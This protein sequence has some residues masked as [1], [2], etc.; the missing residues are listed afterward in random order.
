MK[1]LQRLLSAFFRGSDSGQSLVEY[2]M[3]VGAVALVGIAGFGR[4]GQAVKS[5]LGANARHIEGEGLPTAEGILGSLGADYNELPGWCVK[6]N[7]CFAAG[8]PVQTEHGDRA[9]ESVRVG[10]RIWAR[11]LH[12]GAVALRPVV[13]T[14]R[15]SHV[16]VVDLELSFDLGQTEQLFV[17]RNHLFWVEGAGWVRADALA[18]QP[19][20][21][22]EAQLSAH[23]HEL[24]A[25]PTTVYN[26]EVSDFHSY[27]VGH[28]H[29]L[30][31][32]GDPDSEGCP[33][34]ADDSSNPPPPENPPPA[35]TSGNAPL[36]CGETGGYKDALG[37]GTASRAQR[38]GA[39]G[40][41]RDH[42]PSGQA[43]KTRAA[44]VLDQLV[45][46]QMEEKCRWL[47]PTELDKL[48]EEVA[49]LQ[50]AARASL[51]DAVEDAGFAIA[52]PRKFHYAGR[53]RGSKNYT[54][55][56]PLPGGYY[57]EQGDTRVKRYERDSDDLHLAAQEDIARY[58]RLLGT[59]GLR[60][61]DGNLVPG[62]YTGTDLSSDCRELILKAIE[63][64]RSKTDQQYEQELARV[65]QEQLNKAGLNGLLE[66]KCSEPSASSN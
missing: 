46:Q 17:T 53:T 41:E 18:A 28:S 64:I 39:N 22:T 21:S 57:A 36:E 1:A 8:T 47:S 5:D 9:I 61:A 50:A 66:Q 12:T 11:D 14:Y 45:A 58:E 13:N 4:Y 56:D 54:G 40:M 26:L 10:D 51:P 3:I 55:S 29:V 24:K 16:P 48:E 49:R 44:R 37:G 63:D 35:E 2:L 38:R 30:V 52:V 34:S 43:L 19:L 33:G 27:F 7:Y 25:E 62:E 60:D 42:I 32:N 6:P 65:A 15:T 23:P 20:W 31:H 59:D